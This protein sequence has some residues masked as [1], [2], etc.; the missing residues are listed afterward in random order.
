LQRI[1]NFVGDSHNCQFCSVTRATGKWP[2]ITA[3][4]FDKFGVLYYIATAGGSRDYRNPHSRGDVIVA[5][6]S[7]V[8]VREALPDDTYGELQ[9]FVTHRHDGDAC[10]ETEN[11]SQQWMSVDLGEGRSL[12]PNHYCLRHGNNVPTNRLRHWRFEGSN[13]EVTWMTLREHA[14]DESLSAKQAFAVADWELEGVSESY[15]YFRIKHTGRT[16]DGYN[17]LSCAGIELYGELRRTPF[18]A[19]R[20]LSP[21]QSAWGGGAQRGGATLD[22]TR[23][24]NQIDECWRKPSHALER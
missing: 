15:R 12:V 8:C 6:S 2:R 3:G 11:H 9:R 17:F 1:F 16:W 20:A 22:A 13:D 4:K 24:D 23:I 18:D 14:D 19:A 10:N 21:S 7:I 5:M